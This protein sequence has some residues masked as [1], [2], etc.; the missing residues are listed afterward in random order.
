MSIVSPE[1]YNLTTHLFSIHQAQRCL[2]LVVT[3]GRGVCRVELGEQ[4]E[5]LMESAVSRFNQVV[6]CDQLES[7]LAGSDLAT[8]HWG[9]AKQVVEMVDQSKT[10]EADFPLDLSGTNFQKLVWEGLRS[11]PFGKTTTYQKLAMQIGRPTSVRAVANA[12]GANPVA[13]LIPCHRVLRT[14][15]GIGGYRWGVA[16][17]RTLLSIE[18]SVPDDRQGEL[19]GE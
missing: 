9:L 8:S 14:D 19:F 7:S 6:A 4:H 12:C 1:V 10:A 3:S 11:I 15:G 13:V 17:K 18:Q 5:V 16:H 2:V